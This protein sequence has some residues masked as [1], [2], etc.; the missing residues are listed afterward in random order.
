MI[1]LAEIFQDGMVLQRRKKVS[2]WGTS[3]LAQQIKVRWND[4]VLLETE[5]GEGEF[6]ISLP[7]MEAAF[8]GELHLSG[9]C[10]DHVVLK[11]VDIGEVWIAGG[12]SNMEFTLQCDKDGEQAIE[13]AADEHF[14]YYEVGRYSFEGE[15]EEG[16]KDASHWDRWLPFQKEYA[17]WFSAVSV[18]FAKKLRIELKIPVAVIGC[19]WGGT[20]AVSWIAE[21]ELSGDSELRGLAE[22]YNRTVQSLD[23]EKYLVQDLKKRKHASSPEV[24]SKVDL[25]MK[26]ECLKAPGFFTKLI[27]KWYAKFQGAGP[28][29]EKRP[30]GLFQTMVSRIAGYD[31]RGVI[32]YQ[33]EADA[34]HPFLY[35]KLFEGVIRSWR[36]AWE[37]E[38]PFLFVQLAPFEAWQGCSGENFPVL[39]QQQQEAED[40][41]KDCWM[42]SIMDVGSRFD[43]HPKEKQPV[44]ERLA[45][46]AL[47]K[48]YGQDK[49]CEAPRIS[50]IEKQ[51][52][53]IRV[54]FKDAG[55]GL[56]LK[57]ELDGLFTVTSEERVIGCGVEIEENCVYLRSPEL[58]ED[59]KVVVE[60]A[61]MPYCQMTLYGSTGL[62]AR[63]SA[64]VEIL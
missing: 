52:G 7:E 19:N 22:E 53:I 58:T 57:G 25:L 24:T 35:K 40:E 46:L 33:G 28:Q 43:I 18:Y 9:S 4:E 37:K 50:A 3:S 62:P 64:P 41:I 1:Q 26:E 38:L 30:G 23:M 15:A 51:E 11:N 8:Q 61:Y 56:M 16:L 60:F 42:A 6:K 13:G 45:L 31:C 32:W 36:K 34:D 59:K 17:P 14:R 12:Q 39:R 63:P 47:G 2:V 54:E 29:D 10:G 49:L 44:G 20:P 27:G 21:E 48:M 5:I 55:D